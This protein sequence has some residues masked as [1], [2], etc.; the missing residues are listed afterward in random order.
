MQTFYKI[1][2]A[3]FVIFIGVNIFGINW[4]DGLLNEE[5]SKFVFS[6]AASLLGLIVVIIMINWQKLA[7]KG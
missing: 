2:V 7:A 3:L 1:F 4:S 6:I 5:N